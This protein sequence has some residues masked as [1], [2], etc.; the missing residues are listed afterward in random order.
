MRIKRY[1]MPKGFVY[2]H[3]FKKNISLNRDPVLPDQCS[4][5]QGLVCR[6]HWR[7]KTRETGLLRHQ[8]QITCQRSEYQDKALW[9]YFPT[10]R[11][12]W[13]RGWHARWC[14]RRLCLGLLWLKVPR[15]RQRSRSHSPPGGQIWRMYILFDCFYC[16]VKLF[17]LKEKEALIRT[18]RYKD[19]ND[20][21][22]RPS[23]KK[24]HF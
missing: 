18:K 3:I 14:L 10:D 2:V 9:I 24:S 5:Q 8:L 4:G 20:L 7:G 17:A 12:C 11:W 13:I 6:V 21:H 23:V 19:D 16:K 15:F 22:F 1:I